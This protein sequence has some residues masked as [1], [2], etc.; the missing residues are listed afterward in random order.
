MHFLEWKCLNSDYYNFT[1][2]CS[3]G[4]IWQYSSTGSDNGS[5]RPVGRQPLSEP[6]MVS[7]LTHIYVTRPQWVNSCKIR[8]TS[9]ISKLKYL[10]IF[11]LVAVPHS[12]LPG[13]AFIKRDQPDPWIKDQ[14]KI[15]LLS[16]I[17]PIQLP[18]FVSRGRN[19]ESGIRNHLFEEIY[20]TCNLQRIHTVKGNMKLYSLMW[21]GDFH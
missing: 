13:S 1:E 2:F 15:I 3:W 14:I 4:S 9:W 18:N 20:S 19:Q 7:L 11:S 5:G 12:G 21:P 17:S 10:L 16:T 6:V 8:K